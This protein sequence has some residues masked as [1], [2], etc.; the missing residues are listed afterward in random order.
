MKILIADKFPATHAALL[1]ERGHALTV[2]A[3]LEGPTL[4]GV[5]AGHDVL[6]VRSTK[7]TREAL[8]AADD[9]KLIVRAGSGYNTI[10]FEHAAARGVAVANCPGMNA[11]AVAELTLGLL[12]AID[13]RIPDNV[14]DAREGRWNKKL[15]GQADGLFGKTMGVIGAGRI[16]V[17]VILRARAFGLNLL[18]YDPYQTARWAADLGVE[19]VEDLAEL[20]RRSQIVTVHVPKTPATT[21]IIDA[22][23]LSLLPDGAIVLHASRGGV[24]D[25]AALLEALD[26]KGLRAGLDVY[27]DEPAASAREIDSAIARH[28]RVVATHHI[29]ASTAQ[30]QAAVADEVLRIIDGFVADG[31]V[32]NRVN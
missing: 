2:D 4:P 3:G 30:A 13:R 7:V 8:E 28:P 26:A 5:I 12:L 15:Y 16:G 27:E 6:I 19:L 29:G 18:V 32:R 17:E 14:I 22:E 31:D 24:V 25:D 10:D 20:A 1:E 11:V 23:F 21:H 9:L